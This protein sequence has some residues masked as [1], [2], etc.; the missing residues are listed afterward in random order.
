MLKLPYGISHYKTLI[1]DGYFYQDRTQYIQTLE[2]YG[3]SYLVY[4]RPRRFGKSLLISTLQY[5]Y[6]F[7]YKNEFDKLFG[8]TFIGTHPTRNANAYMVLRFD[9][10][11]INTK[12]EETTYEGFLEKVVLGIKDCF[13]DYEG[14]FLRSH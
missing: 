2:D 9:F 14:Y 8:K 5:Y 1:E 10:S 7:Q 13:I 3:P 6:G 12:N 11:G 4:L